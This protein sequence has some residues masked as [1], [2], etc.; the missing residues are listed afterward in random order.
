[1]EK[2][3]VCTVLSTRNNIDNQTNIS[4]GLDSSAD[5]WIIAYKDYAD[6]KMVE[7]GEAE[8]VGEITLEVTFPIEFCPFCG[9]KMK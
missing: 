6:Q 2:Q 1:M 8:S 7:M 5:V 4:I 3:H 9:K